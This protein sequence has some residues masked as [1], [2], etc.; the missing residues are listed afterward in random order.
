[1]SDTTT[2]GAPDLQQLMA[3]IGAALRASDIPRAIT[4]ARAALDFGI[5]HPTL[6]SLRSLGL[7]QQG[8][9]AEALAD[10]ERARRLA[11]DRF[12]ILN[13]LGLCLM[14]AER[15]REAIEAYDAAIALRPDFAPAWRNRGAALE[16]LG[17]LEA[18]RESHLHAAGLKADYAEPLS[19]L[20]SLAVRRGDLDSARDYAE[21]ALAINPYLPDAAIA[22]ATAEVAAKYAAAAEQRLRDLLN[23]EQVGPFDRALALGVLGDALD[24]QGRPAGAFK[25]WT[26]SAQGMRAMFK[27][28]FEGPG[29]PTLPAALEWMS[30]YFR[31]APAESWDAT[32]R[33][34]VGVGEIS[35]VFLMGFPC[36]GATL[37]DQALVSHPDIVS[38]EERETL[39]E[40]ATYFLA[41]PRGMT[42]LASAS[43]ADLE[44]YRRAYW[45]RVREGGVE[46]TGKVFVDNLPLNTMKLPLIAK[47]F[48]SAKVL[49]AVRDPRDVV[50]SAFR[51][52]FRMNASMYEL[53]TLEG[54][55]RLYVGVM[56]LGQIYAETLK[57]AARRVRYE[58]LVTDFDA[59]MKGVFAFL[60]VPWRDEVRDFAARA[61][62]G[63][64]AAPSAPQAARGLFRGD[65][66]WRRYAVELEPVTPIL[67]PWIERFGYPA[68]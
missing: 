20:A 47:L 10:L 3:E 30:G 60:G 1:M 64:S 43:V 9:I 19:S 24:A 54:A 11:P 39:T 53:L 15:V 31:N 65:A 34:G 35:H 37:L 45:K 25:A 8:R 50:L 40:S 4:L 67:R 28:R 58:D 23:W 33:D 26:D 22:L 7:E 61:Q 32:G 62:A 12:D 38:L 56:D 68:E 17:E 48:P 13:A 66:Q 21:R 57:L 27:D 41:D 14:Q 51:H 55:A 49:V 2:T 5:E 59:E 16:H 18:A 44:P 29:V 63:L 6:L 46:V 36:S 52:R 42:R